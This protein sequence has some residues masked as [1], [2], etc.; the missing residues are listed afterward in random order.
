MRL[1]V[2]IVGLSLVG[3][4]AGW[5]FLGLKLGACIGL[6]IAG[7]GMILDALRSNGNVPPQ[8]TKS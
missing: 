2:A 3:F 1:I 8:E 6:G 7:A 5:A 4:A